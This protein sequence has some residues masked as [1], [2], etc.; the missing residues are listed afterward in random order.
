MR[1]LSTVTFLYLVGM[2]SASPRDVLSYRK[3]QPGKK[4]V[5]A[6]NVTHVKTNIDKGMHKQKQMYTSTAIGEDCKKGNTKNS[7]TRTSKNTVSKSK[8]SRAATITSKTSPGAKTTSKKT[9][10][11]SSQASTTDGS[12]DSK[13][14]TG[15]GTYYDVGLGACGVTNSNSELVA[16]I[17]HVEYGVNANPNNAPVCG[18]CAL[19][20]GPDGKTVT[21][22]IVDSCPACNSGSLDLSPT[23]F[24]KLAPLS[25][26][27]IKIKWSFV[28][29]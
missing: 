9:G 7:C 2:V 13:Q 15:E 23:A 29:C 25:A 28:S 21:V 11:N 22:K 17:S 1:C 16:A 14:Y 5:G 24:Q 27:R 10:S 19:V 4:N 18:K 12:K 6:H 8:A 20:T 3:H 26:G